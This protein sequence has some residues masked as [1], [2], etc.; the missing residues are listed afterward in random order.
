LSHITL[1]MNVQP[2]GWPAAR[3]FRYTFLGCF[4]TP[5]GSDSGIC[6]GRRDGDTIRQRF[7]KSCES[8]YG[9]GTL[10]AS[11]AEARAPKQGH[12]T[13]SQFTN[14]VFVADPADVLSFSA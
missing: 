4:A 9:R 5:M 11:F 10:A 2:F 13:E 14:S 12:G 8:K 6:I 1:P 3:S 7:S